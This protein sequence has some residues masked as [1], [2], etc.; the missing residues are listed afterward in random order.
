MS[1][2]KKLYLI[3][4][5]FIIITA[6][7]QNELITN[8][9][10]LTT[11]LEALKNQ[12]SPLALQ[13]QEEITWSHTLSSLRAFFSKNV[14]EKKLNRQIYTPAIISAQEFKQAIR[15]C[16]QKIKEV[17]DNNTWVN[18]PQGNRIPASAYELREKKSY[19]YTQKLLIPS[20][21]EVVFWGDI[22]G[23]ASS[24]LRSLRRL[25]HNKF[26]DDN[27]KIIKNN[28]YLVF[29]G[30]HVDR[31]T[32]GVEVLYLIM[33]LKIENP[34]Q[35]IIL[36]GNHEDYKMN[37]HYTFS[38]EIEKKYP[39]QEVDEIFSFFGLLP[40]A[41]Y[42]GTG[43]NYI[44]CCHGG[45]E[46]GYLP[47]KLLALPEVISFELIHELN[48]QTNFDDMLRKMQNNE[49]LQGFNINYLKNYASEDPDMLSE[50]TNINISPDKSI[51]TGFM[52]N[53]F[54]A[55]PK[56]EEIIEINGKLLS[57]ANDKKFKEQY[58]IFNEGRE[59]G[60]MLGEII[61]KNILTLSSDEQHIIHSVFRG[62]QHNSSMPQLWDTKGLFNLWNGTVLTFL[63]AP[64]SGLRFDYD[65]FAILTTDQSFDTWQ[66]DHYWQDLKVSK[67]FEHVRKPLTEIGKL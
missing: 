39:L 31:G 1:L 9:A 43:K 8:L 15:L 2:V 35:V 6:E 59:T 14:S 11:H 28:G 16:T 23:S 45:L 62:H 50:L 61:T 20:G 40:Q 32:Y 46:I 52:W 66:I 53:D 48:R 42:L 18:S 24:L 19:L 27:F 22:H 58:L 41:L 44:Q 25:Y 33:R 57:D 54:M 51:E 13:A 60:F 10:I 17:N 37:K 65:T 30:D 26:I 21:S 36:R 7:N 67:G 34:E 38:K 55:K 49:L 56:A 4:L 5:Q 3:C 12:V 63:S 29:L 64:D 47:K